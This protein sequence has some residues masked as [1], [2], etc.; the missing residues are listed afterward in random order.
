MDFIQGF[1]RNQLQMISF[2]EF[3]KPDS[4]ARI[5]DLFVDILPLNN[6]GFKDTFEQEG[7]PPYSPSDLLKF[8]L[9]GYKNHLRSS[10]KL[11]HACQVNLEVIW[12]IKGLKP[13]AR[14]IAYFRKNNAKAFK[15]AFRYFV[16]ILK[17]L[18]L[19]DGQTIAIDSFKIRAQNASKNNFN[20]KKIDRHIKYIDDKIDD[21]QKQL[22][23]E[24]SVDKQEDIN[25]KIVYN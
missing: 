3:V 4:W 16:V 5:V 12:L 17:D 7:R 11:A 1:N 9:Y 13:S 14:K 23:Q 2:D 6:L 22:E 18:N 24:D 19:I 8:Y 15:Q 25:Q 20:Q 21:Y 10:R